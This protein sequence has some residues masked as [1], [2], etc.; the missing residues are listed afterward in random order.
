MLYILYLIAWIV[1][2]FLISFYLHKKV[3]LFKK[4]KGVLILFLV[5]LMLTILHNML[6]VLLEMEDMVLLLISVLCFSIF[7]WLIVLQLVQK[8]VSTKQC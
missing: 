3:N 4:F 8:V 2:T 1:A 7:S 5:F 6:S